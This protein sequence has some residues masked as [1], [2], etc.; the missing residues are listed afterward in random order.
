M[1]GEC[2]PG[3]T[4]VWFTINQKLLE[5][6]DALVP[7]RRRSRELERLVRSEVLRRKYGD[8]VPRELAELLALI[9]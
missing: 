7:L 1:Q 5:E 4:T 8:H 9:D 6:F 2:R 3:A